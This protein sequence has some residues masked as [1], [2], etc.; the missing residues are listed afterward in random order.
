MTKPC[1]EAGSKRNDVLFGSR[2]TDF[3]EFSQIDRICQ[4]DGL[5]DLLVIVS[6]LVNSHEWRDLLLSSQAHHQLAQAIWQKQCGDAAT[7]M[8][9]L[10][11][12]LRTRECDVYSVE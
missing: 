5:D 1:H 4:A 2:P 8:D 3:S 10:L 6:E 11:A 7:A 12:T 9:S